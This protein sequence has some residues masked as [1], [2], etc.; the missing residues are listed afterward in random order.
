[1]LVEYWSSHSSD[2]FSPSNL[3]VPCEKAVIV[4]SLSRKSNPAQLIKYV[5]RYVLNPSK[6]PD[7]DAT[8]IRHN[9]KSR[10]VDGYIK[11][12]KANESRRIRHQKNNVLLHHIIL[13]WN[14]KDAAKVTPEKIKAMAKEFIVLRGKKNLFLGASHHDRSHV[15]LHLVMSG[16]DLT[17]RSNRISRSA[18]AAIKLQLDD[19]QKKHFPELSHSLPAH[20]RSSQAAP[21]IDRRQGRLSQKEQVMQA[22]Q[23]AYHKAKSPESF[24]L[25]VRAM[26]HEPYY[27]GG[28]LTGITLETGRKFRFRS[29]RIMP[30]QIA[31]LN[32]VT[33]ELSTLKAIR[34]RQQRRD[35]ELRNGNDM[36]QSETVRNQKILEGLRSVSRGARGHVLER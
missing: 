26:G 23:S 1:M 17:G 27:R 14:T 25:A 7:S 5:L 24:V 4:K 33:K 29:L 6:A 15:H 8:V 2:V 19:F 21:L 20:G 3:P 22:I 13:S 35:R 30:Q 18:F 32:Q 31:E 28:T 16:S 34:S 36:K 10:D 11:E 9:I 12:F